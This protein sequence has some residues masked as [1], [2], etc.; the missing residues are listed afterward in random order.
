MGVV[1]TT[2]T[3]SRRATFFG[4]VVAPPGALAPLRP[5]MDY[6]TAKHLAPALIGP[7]RLT[8]ER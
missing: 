1:V 6:A 2:I 3:R 5:H 4:K 8:F 7:W